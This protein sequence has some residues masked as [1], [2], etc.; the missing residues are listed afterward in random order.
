MYHYPGEY[1]TD[2]CITRHQGVFH[3]FH[4]RG[5]RWTW[6]VGYHEIDLGHA[7]SEDLR[8]WT[9]QK[10]V[11]PVGPPG[12]WD[13]AGVWA[14]D[15]IEVDGTYYLYYT[16]ADEKRNQKIGL[17]TSTDLMRWRKHP[18]NPV[19][20][21]GRWS[22]WERGEGNAGRD[23]MIFH[24]RKRACYFMYYTATLADGRPC[25]ALARS[26]DLVNWEDLGPTYIEEYSSYNRCES[27]YLVQHN[28][29]YYLFYSAKGGPQSKGHSPSDFA[30]FDIVY[31]VSDDPTT[32]WT[33][34]KNH[35]LLKGWVCASEHPTFDGTTYMFY[36]IQE[37]VEGIW[38]ASSLSDP[39]IIQWNADGT[40]KI[41]EHL[42]GNVGRRTLFLAGENSYNDWY[43]TSG[44]TITPEGSMAINTEGADAYLVNPLWGRD[45]AVEV[46]VQ[47]N[48]G[49]EASLLVRSNP[50]GTSGYR[51]ALDF[52]RSQI[53]IWRCLYQQEEK[54]IAGRSVDVGPGQWHKLKVVIQ[55]KF[56]DVYVDDG[57]QIVR[58][59]RIFE[60]GCFG[61]HA[62]GQLHFRHLYACEYLGPERLTGDSWEKRCLPRYLFPST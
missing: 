32:G 8:R 31:L 40:V 29:R 9:P 52:S 2:F 24:D 54:L 15:V 59:N 34:P 48:A 44:W 26:A 11:V 27:A 57:L 36:V 17:A 41:A 53:A 46:Q 14:P 7:I 33:K 49:S 47:G 13:E 50:S 21:P 16:G 38:G 30:H 20:V 60:D 43:Q 1:V 6:P 5:E 58:T 25:I 4:I 10:P 19:I 55:D 61:I 3:L 56:I 39:K 22:D 51:I 12:E 45:L 62:R 35:E 42:P 18:H 37:E 28:E 23:G